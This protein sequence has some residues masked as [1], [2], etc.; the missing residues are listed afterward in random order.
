M[1]QNSLT[2]SLGPRFGQDSADEQRLPNALTRLGHGKRRSW[3]ARLRV[4]RDDQMR[5]VEERRRP[6]ADGPHARLGVQPRDYA[7]KLGTLTSLVGRSVNVHLLAGARI[8]IEI[9]GFHDQSTRQSIRTNDD[10]QPTPRSGPNRGAAVRSTRFA[11]KQRP[12]GGMPALCG[13]ATA[14]PNMRE[15][16]G[17]AARARPPGTIGQAPSTCSWRPWPRKCCSSDA[18]CSAA[19]EICA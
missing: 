13:K 1:A 15:L 12:A 17:Y 18:A 8:R 2:L 10:E 3:L 6:I 9:A 4:V 11:C 5:G 14:A 7:G 16:P 19:Q